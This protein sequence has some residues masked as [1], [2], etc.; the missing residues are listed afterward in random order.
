MSYARPPTVAEHRALQRMTRGA[1][2]RVSQRAH[3]IWLSAQHYPVPELPPLFGMS[4]AT[5][6]FWIRRFEAS[7]PAGLS[8]EP[9]SGR[10]R[11]LEPG[12]LETMRTMRQ[13][14]PS[15]AGSLATFWTV[16]M[17]AL[18]VLPR[19]GVHRSASALRGTWREL[20]R[21]WGR[22]RLARPRKTEPATARQPWL[23][24]QAVG[25]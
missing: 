7:G 13:D 23:M 11:T 21:R 9:R 22:P 25:E 10:P 1:M 19:C 5:V 8:D 24:A 12:G 16:A 20:G 2:G 14:D 15:H 17:L 6:R 18:A 4:R 3:L